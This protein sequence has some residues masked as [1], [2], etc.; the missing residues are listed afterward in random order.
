MF[1]AGSNIGRILVPAGRTD[2]DTAQMVVPAQ[3]A[4]PA[5]LHARCA[6]LHLSRTS[7]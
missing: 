4:D 7:L 5:A 1:Y 3:D 6:E 2:C